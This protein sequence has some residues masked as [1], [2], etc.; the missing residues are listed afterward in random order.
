MGFDSSVRLV[1]STGK[2][3]DV[4]RRALRIASHFDNLIDSCQT[5]Q[6]S[7]ALSFPD[8]ISDSLA[9]F[10]VSYLLH[11]NGTDPNVFKTADVPSDDISD[12]VSDKWDASFI[13]RLSEHDLLAFDVAEGKTTYE[14]EALSVECACASLTGTEP[15]SGPLPTESFL[16]SWPCSTISHLNDPL[17]RKIV[18]KVQ[19]LRDNRINQS[20]WV[21]SRESVFAICN[22]VAPKLGMKGLERLA[23]AKINSW[24]VGK[25]AIL[26][27]FSLTEGTRDEKAGIVRLLRELERL[28]VTSKLCEQPLRKK[29]RIALI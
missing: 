16:K 17:R 23:A 18:D 4:P 12:W 10:V 2:E 29:C 15:P 26:Q 5:A 27:S 20:S 21:T 7:L 19:F 28:P 24:K 14:Q 11:H 25:P 13:E 1:T 6:D 9:E 8:G 3:Y 22:D